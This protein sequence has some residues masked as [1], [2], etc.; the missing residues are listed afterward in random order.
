MYTN[1]YKIFESLLPDPSNVNFK[2]HNH[3]EYEVLLF[4]EGDAKYIVED[5]TYTLEPY[6]VI[7]IHKN[8]LHRIYHNSETPYH[9]IILWVEPEFFTANH[10]TEYEKQFLKAPVNTGHKIPASLVR[11]SGLLDAFLRY[12]KYSE[13]FTLD[14][15]MPILKTT[16]I[17]ILYLINKITLFSDADLTK[18]PVKSVILYINNHYTE[19]IS[20]DFLENKFFI[21]KYYLCRAFRKSTGLT[22]HE[23]IR[24][25]RLTK[26]RELCEAG[27]NIS[28]ASI[29]SGFRDYSSFYRAYQK[30]YGVSPSSDLF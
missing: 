3:N 11:S 14:G 1:Y 19:D 16:L 10:C 20:L 25:K 7:I 27:L 22:I 30:E 6:D 23:Y 15:D 29:Q 9:R 4:L 12:Q 17:E 13:N 2:L 8:E 18:T 24:R 26:V 21:S 28:N 5:K